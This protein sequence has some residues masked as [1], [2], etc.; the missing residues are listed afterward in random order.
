[1]QG[2]E[3]VEAEPAVGS[4][5]S[6]RRRSSSI[7]QPALAA[8]ADD[9]DEASEWAAEAYAAVA[10]KTSTKAPK[11]SSV[12]GTEAVEA[13]PAVGL[14]GSSR[15]RSSAIAQSILS[16]PDDVE[17]LALNISCVPDPKPATAFKDELS[18][19]VEEKSDPLSSSQLLLSPNDPLG[20]S[21]LLEMRAVIPD[22][23]SA[24]PDNSK[25][26]MS[27]SRSRRISA[28]VASSN[29]LVMPVNNAGAGIATAH[30]DEEN[31]SEISTSKGRKSRK[32]TTHKP[33][34]QQTDE[35]MSSSACTAAP[36]TISAE[37]ESTSVKI[38]RSSI[39]KLELV[40][41]DDELECQV[42]KR[43]VDF[44]RK[45]LNTRRSR[46]SVSA[47]SMEEV[48]HG[49]DPE[50]EQESSQCAAKT[51]PRSRRARSSVLAQNLDA[52]EEDMTHGETVQIRRS[53]KSVSVTDKR[54]A[55]AGQLVSA[56]EIHSENDGKANRRTARSASAN[57]KDNTKQTDQVEKAV[58]DQLC[59]VE[60]QNETP[61]LQEATDNKK[62][63]SSKR[64]SIAV[65]PEAL[66][67]L[68]E[69]TNSV[70][71]RTRKSISVTS[72]DPKDIIG[73]PECL[74]TSSVK[75]VAAPPRN[76]LRRPRKEV[77]VDF[78]KKT[79]V[80]DQ[81]IVEEVLPTKRRKAPAAKP[82]PSIETITIGPEVDAGKSILKRSSSKVAGSKRG[83][84]VEEEGSK[85][86]A[87]RAAAVHVSIGA[88]TEY[89]ITPRKKTDVQVLITPCLH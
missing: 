16:L 14:P 38:S 63:R 4:S 53:R 73:L 23:S 50:K 2:T 83:A 67:S 52:I 22:S 24:L 70:V 12:P 7:A 20:S 46:L 55:D 77:D 21:M 78:E 1:M 65:V 19:V 64:V 29:V 89:A 51:Q 76:S 69:K 75:E 85:K 5:G 36:K 35:M 33:D 82:Q 80:M 13:E 3:A 61:A 34:A 66:S 41:E 71:R 79:E 18:S 57:Q 62:R 81:P 31:K 58:S 42:E 56:P 28:K 11:R 15:R 9:A 74:D 6:S 45:V 44:G 47:K 40:K 86:K 32:S 30:I 26:S 8:Q 25:T 87:K 60:L 39:K 43:D 59:S 72:H 54:E 27:K 49:V 10:P 68:E 37:L 84:E 48:L 17:C 88:T